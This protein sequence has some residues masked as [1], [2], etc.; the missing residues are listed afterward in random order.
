M[1]IALLITAALLA[2]CATTPPPPHATP[3]T[4]RNVDAPVITEAWHSPSVTV[5]V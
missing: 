5:T 2:G 3:V 1:R 4:A